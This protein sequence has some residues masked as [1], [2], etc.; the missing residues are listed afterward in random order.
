MKKYYK[1]GLVVILALTLVVALAACG[2]AVNSGS[3]DVTNDAA[4]DVTAAQPEEP[5]KAGYNGKTLRIAWWG[6]D[7]RTNMT[8]EIIKNFEGMYPGLSIEVEYAGFSDYFTKLNTQAAGG[9]LPDVIQMDYSQITSFAENNLLVDLTNYINDG[10]LD[11]SNVDN[12]LL[13]GGIVNGGMYGICAGVN[14]PCILYDASIL[15]KANVTLSDTP[16]WPEFLDASQ[17]VYKA[18]GIKNYCMSSSFINYLDMFVRSLGAT[19][20]AADGK[21]VGFTPEMLAQLWDYQLTAIEDGSALEPGEYTGEENA[22]IGKGYSWAVHASTN[23]LASFEK[24]NGDRALTIACHPIAANATE[25]NAT[26]IK[27]SQLWSVTSTSE[28][29][30]LAAAYINYFTN[31]ISVY[32]IC[33]ANRGIPISSVVREHLNA[34][35]SEADQKVNTFIDFLSNGNSTP[36]S[37]AAPSAGSEAITVINNYFEQMWYKQFSH[38][39]LP[40]IAQKVVN[41]MNAILGAAKQ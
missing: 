37:P 2:A 10:T 33:G 40:E 12:S 29:P 31:E 30:D 26:Y 5:S 19:V 1:K 7:I 18:T 13:S 23:N 24:T 35:A 11:M 17:K 6:D 9:Q 41:E 15:E 38:D 3:K 21:S 36:I 27:P 39:K 8:T 4:K 32:D 14:A 20:Y 25:P 22:V 28:V 34:G 16:T